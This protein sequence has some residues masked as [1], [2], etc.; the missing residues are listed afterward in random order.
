MNKIQI[1]GLGIIIL[2]GIASYFYEENNIISI[3]SG[4]LCAVGLTFVLKW[5]PF[6]NR[7]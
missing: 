5:F 6:Q 4:V 7:N 3:L 2:G 1:I